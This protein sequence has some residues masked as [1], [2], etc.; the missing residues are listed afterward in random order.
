VISQSLGLDCGIN[1]KREGHSKKEPPSPDGF[2][3]VVFI[4]GT[5]GGFSPG[6]ASDTSLH[7]A[8][9]HQYP[10]R[11]TAVDLQCPR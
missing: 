3:A 4:I 11:K 2:L 7:G 10:T 9:G 6:G 1:S 5:A 8:D